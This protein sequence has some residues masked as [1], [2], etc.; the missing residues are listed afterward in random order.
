MLR[1]FLIEFM[2]FAGHLKAID[3]WLDGDSDC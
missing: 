3:F 1:Y 2:D